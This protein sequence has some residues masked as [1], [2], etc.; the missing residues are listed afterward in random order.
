MIPWFLAGIF[1]L[2]LFNGCALWNSL[3]GEEELTPAELMSQ[4]VEDFNDGKFEAATES[5]QKIKDRY[6]YSE[7]AVKAE[8]KM[9]DALYERDLFDEAYDEYTEFEKLHPR[10]PEIPYVV[11]QKGMCNFSRVSTIDRDQS[12]TW[13]AKEDFERLIKRYRRS[14]Y[15]ERAR[16]KVREC[17]IKLAEH[18]LYVGNFYFKM[19]K[20]Q[21]A[22]SRYIYLIENY[23]DVGQYYEALEKI[24]ICREKLAEE[25]NEEGM[26]WWGRLKSSVFN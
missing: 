26:S 21:P 8:L 4:G 5:F 14:A 6:P 9:A 16:R 13:K 22:M 1:I 23:P 25:K 2:L 12:Y 7:F 18:E 20:Y 10:N 19:E 17:Y 24:K 15:T 3:F 11:F